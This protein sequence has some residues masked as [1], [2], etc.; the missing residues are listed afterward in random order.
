M[1]S[2]VENLEALMAD[3]HKT[4]GWSWVHEEPLWT[5]WP[6]EKFGALPHAFILCFVSNLTLATS[7]A[8]LPRFYHR[9]LEQHAELAER[10]RS[11]SITFEESRDV[12]NQWM[13]EPDLEEEG[14]DAKWEDLC[15][16][17]I[18]KWGTR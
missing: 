16:A 13:E 15:I 12:A 7:F 11:H 6:L 18:D 1:V 8:E 2:I 9:S 17:E 5:T 14:W 4:K 3:A 10:L